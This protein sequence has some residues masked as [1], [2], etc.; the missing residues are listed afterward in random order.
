VGTRITESFV[1]FTYPFKLAPLD[2]ELAAGTYRVVTDDE[3]ISGMT[4]LAFRRIATMLHTPA[5]AIRS[6][7][8]Q[9]FEI[10]PDDLAAAIESDSQRRISLE[11]DSQ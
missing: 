7:S 3:E 4:Y 9:V 5:L 2:V 6:S 8:H 11:G 1:S 10:D